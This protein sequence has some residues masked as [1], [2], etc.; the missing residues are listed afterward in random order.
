MKKNR[1][2]LT[3]I[4]C[5]SI[6]AAASVGVVMAQSPTILAGGSTQVEQ[7]AGPG[8]ADQAQEQEAVMESICVWGPVTD[9]ADGKIMIDN[10]SG[11]SSAGDM[12]LTV[13]DETTRMLDAV[14]GFPVSLEDVEVGQVIYAY[15]GQAMTMSLPPM[16][17][18]SMIITG[19][20]ADSKVPEYVT[21]KSMEWH[22][23]GDWT[24]TSTEGVVYEIPAD[25]PVSPY[26]TRNI[27]TLEDVAEG[28]QLMVWSSDENVGQKLLLFAE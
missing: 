2:I 27:V 7:E 24:L 21:V 16:T 28:R 23:N 22:E 1:Q 10:Q 9:V 14:D 17:N 3:A 4:C 8:V 25:C 13:G 26:M 15:I 6:L 20:P 18:A 12:I 5:T 11:I 19:I